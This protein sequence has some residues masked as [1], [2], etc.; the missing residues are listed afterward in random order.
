MQRSLLAQRYAAAYLNIYGTQYTREHIQLIEQLL[1]YLNKHKK[2]LFYLKLSC[3]NPLVKK[4]ILMNVFA[5]Y[6]LTDTVSTLLDL[7]IAHKRLFMIIEVLQSIVQTYKK[8]H[9]IITWVI[10]SPAVLQQTDLETIYQFLE[11]K[12]GMRAEYTSII[13]K[14]VLAGIRIQSG[15]LLWEYS[16]RQQLKKLMAL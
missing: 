8:R 15:T 1:Q 13:D 3:I 5:R 4:S 16:A 14:N 11:N 10:K 7:L 9:A 12:T 2:A 6:G